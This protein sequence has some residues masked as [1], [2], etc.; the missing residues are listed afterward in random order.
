MNAGI[1][2]AAIL[3]LFSGDFVPDVL[4]APPRDL[5][6]LVSS[7]LVLTQA[8]VALDE[9][10]LIAALSA[11]KTPPTAAH[12]QRAIDDL[13]AED[14]QVRRRAA[15][16]LRG[17][18]EH[19][20]PFLAKAAD[21]ENA[22]LRATALEL[23]TEINEA[24]GRPAAKRD[25][26]YVKKL[27]AIRQLEKT[28]SRK[29]LAALKTMAE[30]EDITLAD[31]A[32]E[33]IA[34]I[35]GE[36]IAP[37]DT[38]KALDEIAGRLPD[39][40][41]FVGVLDLSRNRTS[42]T[43]REIVGP[44]LEDAAR[45]PLLEA[46]GGERM[47]EQIGRMQDEAERGIV[48]VIGLLGNLRIDA[49]VMLTSD[50]LPD[51]TGYAA[52]IFKG[53]CDPE[54]LRGVLAAETREQNRYTVGEHVVYCDPGDLA[55][56]V[57]DRHTVAITV[58]PGRYQNVAMRMILTNLDRN[59][60]RPLPPR[61][62]KA[63]DMVV[64][65][66]HALAVS[67]ALSDLQKAFLAVELGEEIERAV[68]R[69]ERNPRPERG[70]EIAGGRM[71][72]NLQ[73]VEAF[74]GVVDRKGTL[75]L[76]ATCESPESAAI[77]DASLANVHK[78]IHTMI[79]QAAAEMPAETKALFG[80]DKPDA[81]FWL[82]AL[83]DRTLTVTADIGTVAQRFGSM[84]IGLRTRRRPERIPRQEEARRRAEAE[85]RE[86]AEAARREALEARAA[87]R[88]AEEEARARKAAEEERRRVAV[89]Q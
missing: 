58:G 49:I 51:D 11:E 24:M 62:R 55:V 6:A 63:F 3:M 75:T 76:Q 82:S 33:A 88:A 37:P 60:E 87:A 78:E 40:V 73:G 64:N 50:N 10:S 32:A 7:E 22:T 43:L 5:A 17:A 65:E 12:L 83:E 16:R 1:G 28:K 86:A 72:M 8:G 35:N 84:M 89:P 14:P 27:F 44:L 45:Q 29:A 26:A 54:R 59:E 77:L 9:D 38:A 74:T 39:N 80:L 18:R 31:A 79:A 15:E 47:K 56:C 52:W 21:S 23:L 20:V 30:G 42:R 68:E 4:Y 2:F 57:L 85:A 70:I 34:I 81:A 48:E 66:G 25:D 67:G 53:L 41:G 19:A 46:M 61:L 71:L 69:Q 36:E 13:L